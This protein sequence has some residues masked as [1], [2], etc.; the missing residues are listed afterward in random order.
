MSAICGA[1]CFTSDRCELK[2][3]PC[4][5]PTS[6]KP[7]PVPAT[8][9]LATAAADTILTA[10][11]TLNDVVSFL[12]SSSV[13]VMVIVMVI[14]IVIVMCSPQGRSVTSCK[15]TYN[16]DGLGEVHWCLVGCCGCRLM[17]VK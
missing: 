12:Y 3:T 9:E 16:C 15:Q 13:I 6:K 17:F 14:V 7:P 11:E 1:R 10:V 8:V 5:D 2:Y 4:N